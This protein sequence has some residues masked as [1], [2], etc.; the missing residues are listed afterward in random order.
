MRRIETGRGN[1]LDLPATCLRSAD[2]RCCH[3]ESAG[4]FAIDRAGLVGADGPTHAGSFDLSYLRCI[5]N[6]T[7]MTPA[8]EN[9]CRQMLYTAFQ[10]DTPAAV[11]YPRGSGPGVQ[12]Q[13]EMQTIPLGKGEIRRQGKQIALLAFGSML[14]P[15]SKREMN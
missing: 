1:L 9:E 15:V 7:V 4:C 2:P 3:S 10:L 6:I 13:Q 14:T 12:I 8:D 11:R 5:P